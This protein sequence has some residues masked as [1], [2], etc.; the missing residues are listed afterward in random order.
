MKVLDS[1][2]DYLL[3]NN[4]DEGFTRLTFFK[5]RKINGSGYSGTTTQEVIR[6]L[7][8]R[9]TFVESQAPHRINSECIDLLRRVI[10]LHEIRA[11]ERHGQDILL[12]SQKLNELIIDGKI[13]NIE[14]RFDGHIYPVI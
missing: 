3:Q 8:D 13:E 6:S 11:A 7:I 10:Y 1:G 4:K 12:T 9:I 14:T 2:H 5:D